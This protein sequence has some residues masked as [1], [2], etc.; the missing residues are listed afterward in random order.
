MS[1][2]SILETATSVFADGY[3]SLIGMGLGVYLNGLSEDFSIPLCQKPSISHGDTS[4]NPVLNVESS[5][6]CIPE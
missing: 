3:T 4:F 6:H 1:R 5:R 2:L